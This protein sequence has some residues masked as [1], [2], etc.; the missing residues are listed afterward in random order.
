MVSA[1][2]VAA[3]RNPLLLGDPS[4]SQGTAGGP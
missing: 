1:D 3:D 4:G 2:K